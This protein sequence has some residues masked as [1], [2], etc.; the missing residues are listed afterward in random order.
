MKKLSF[1]LSLLLFA[2]GTATA[3]KI[4]SVS[5]INES[6]SYTLQAVDTS[7]GALYYNSESS[8]YLWSTGKN[9]IA[10]D[11]SSEAQQWNF[12]STGTESQYY[13]KNVASNTYIGSTSNPW[14]LV[15]ESNRAAFIVEAGSSNGFVIKSAQTNNLINISNTYD[16]G[17]DCLYNSQD[18]GN[19]FIITNVTNVSTIDVTYKV[20]L[21]G[22]DVASATAT[23][24]VGD[25]A[26]LPSSLKKDYCSY[27]LDVTTIAAN[28]ATV[29]ATCT[30]SLPFTISESYDNATWYYLNFNTSV[31]KTYFT[32][33]SS[34]EPNVKTP[35]GYTNG[36]KNAQWAFV[37]TYNPYKDVNSFTIYNR[38]AGS[39]LI[40][41]TKIGAGNN[42]NNGGNTYAVMD[43]AGSETN[44]L[45]KW[46]IANWAAISGGFTLANEE[47]V[48][49]N[50]RSA[51][52]L[53]YWTNAD[54][55]SVISVTEVTDVEEKETIPYG[56]Q[57]EGT[58]YIN[59]GT[60]AT[61]LST[62][63]QW[64]VLYNNG[65]NCYVHEEQ[66]ALKMRAPSTA[67]L[68]NA[69]ASEKLGYLFKLIDGGNGTYK[70]LSANGVSF[71]L[72][73]NNS[74]VVTS[75]TDYS[76]LNTFNITQIGENAGY[77]Y[78]QQTSDNIVADGQQ[79]GYS[80]VGWGT[81]APSATN[82]NG[83]YSFIP[84]TLTD[85]IA[86]YHVTFS[87]DK[88]YTIS[89]ANRGNWAYI[90]SYTYSNTDE[91]GNT[92]TSF[93]GENALVSTQVNGLNETVEDANKQFA[94]LTSDNNNYY[95]YNI[96]SKKFVTV[97][98]SKAPLSVAPTTTG[99]QIIDNATNSNEYP[100]VVAIDDKQIA[101]SNG[102]TN[103]GGIISSYNNLEDEGNQVR[104]TEVEGASAEVTIALARIKAFETSLA[105]VNIGTTYGTYASSEDYTQ[106]LTALKAEIANADATSESIEKAVNALTD[107]KANLKLNVPADGAF[108]RIKSHNTSSAYLASDNSTSYN[109]RANYSTDKDN[110]TIFCYKDGY[111]VNYKTGLYICNNSNMAG[112]NG[113]QA[114]GAAFSFVANTN[115]T[116]EGAGVYYVNYVGNNN[117]TRHL[118]AQDANYTDAGNGTPNNVRYTFDLEAVESLPVTITSAGYATL[119]APQA[120]TI[121]EGVTAYTV[122][123]S[124]NSANLT[125][126]EDGVIP[127]NTGVVL[128]GETGDYNFAITTTDATKTSD[129]SG[130]IP[131]TT[132]S[133]DNNPYILAKKNAG[134]GFYEMTSESD[135]NIHGFRAYFSAPEA[136]ASAFIFNF[137]DAT[138]IDSINA[139]S[140]DKNTPIYDLSGRRVQKAVK[141]VY[142]QGG[143][144]IYV[145]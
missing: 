52:N 6:N 27:A 25:Q 69:A 118:Y 120:L 70:F 92:T 3:Q 39:N 127:A 8:N 7:R 44:T 76:N 35:V 72:G 32:Y 107:A 65:R 23:H 131:T 24:Y 108:I 135:R 75:Y 136:G 102:Y 81:S 4:S 80:F 58:K 12:I 122:S 105:T 106:A 19:N 67:N 90:P 10:Y 51:D 2:V 87:N 145:K 126:I 116:T 133:A 121:P 94:I 33:D 18:N 43:G 15:D 97:D 77:F 61:T 132:I 54:A 74:S 37:G 66:T 79:A 111:L 29:I 112:Y 38:A 14:T 71:S 101:I 9:S 63:N 45:N 30:V 123:M 57:I 125:A 119:Y 86:D 88:V 13:I 129:L 95:I 41:A 113:V 93:S 42:D 64:Y 22:V 100:Y 91:D 128:A 60:S 84:V 46:S 110:S 142:I 53:A 103:L 89:T 28:T 137:G 21:N 49:L 48:R 99:T 55:G 62:D 34:A 114:A 115:V 1:L 68:Q 36:D 47:G 117:A 20:V 140:A 59:L 124:E 139:I 109:T 31:G 98:G 138:G 143:K 85:Q 104:F 26:S 134:V 144:K 11:A 40:L 50:R 130:I 78:I 73:Q 141:G 17:T 56:S 16:Y 82:S 83:S 96:A 5:E